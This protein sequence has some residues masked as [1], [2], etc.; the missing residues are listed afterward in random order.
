[1]LF[2]ALISQPMAEMVACLHRGKVDVVR[3]GQA[4]QPL[5]SPYLVQLAATREGP[6]DARI[7]SVTRGRS[8]GE[9]CYAIASQRASGVF[10]QVPG[11][12]KEQ[13]LFHSVETHLSELDFSFADGALACTVAAERGTSAIGVL[14]DD[15]NHLLV[16]QA[17]SA[18]SA[19]RSTGL[20]LSERSSGP[21]GR[22]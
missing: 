1:V 21:A 12:G 20:T 8:S 3:R 16:I 4:A 5:E 22:A 10:A 19:G 17:R 14:S 13:R 15:G 11:S 2:F 9:L 7:V 6:A 18:D